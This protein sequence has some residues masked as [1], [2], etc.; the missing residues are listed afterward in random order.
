V[1]GEVCDSSG[2]PVW[3]TLPIDPERIGMEPAN[4]KRARILNK[5]DLITL[6]VVLMIVLVVNAITLIVVF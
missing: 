1:S 6:I 5:P 2:A 3:R 4:S